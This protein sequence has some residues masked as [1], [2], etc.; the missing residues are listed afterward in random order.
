MHYACIIALTQINIANQA[1]PGTRLIF[2]IV[3]STNVCMHVCVCLPSKA[4]ITN[5][6]L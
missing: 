5:G 2:E 6:V 3:L 4:L 1:G